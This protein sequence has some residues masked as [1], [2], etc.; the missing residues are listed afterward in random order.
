[1]T[2]AEEQ[3]IRNIIARLQREH[4]GCS[5]GGGNAELDLLEERNKRTAP[6]NR[7]ECT[8]R[9]YVDTWLI[10]PLACLLPGAGRDTKLAQSMSGR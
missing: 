9:V 2:K 7:I 3:T 8:A 4:L 6:F 10:G 1:M 5:H